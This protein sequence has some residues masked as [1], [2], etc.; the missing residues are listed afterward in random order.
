MQK[1]CNT[2]KKYKTVWNHA[3]LRKCSR[4]RHIGRVGT[5]QI[6]RSV[7]LDICLDRVPI[8][9]TGILFDATSRVV[10][11][12]LGD[13]VK[14]RHDRPGCIRKVGDGVHCR[15]AGC[16]G[17]GRIQSRA[18]RG[19]RVESERSRVVDLKTLRKMKMVKIDEDI[20]TVLR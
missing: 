12:R 2:A 20:E 18:R 14:K 1:Q 13:R 8:R 6:C 9:S 4:P 10:H 15:S 11:D 16:S 5:H 17:G 19:H 7:G 3:Q